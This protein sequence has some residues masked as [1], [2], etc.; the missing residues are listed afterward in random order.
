MSEEANMYQMPGA[1]AH[2][3]DSAMEAGAITETMMH[4]LRGA[5]PWLRFMGILAFISCGLLVLAGIVFT[6]A[7]MIGSSLFSGGWGDSYSSAGL[8]YFAL[9]ALYFFPASFMYRCGSKLRDYSLSHS[10]HDLETALKNNKSL[11]KFIGIIA[12]VCIAALPV[13]FIIAAVIGI[14]AFL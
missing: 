4:Y 12:I 8:I 6:I 7:T 3:A 2:A 11:W 13:L 5:S 14:S 9:G 10:A 1:E